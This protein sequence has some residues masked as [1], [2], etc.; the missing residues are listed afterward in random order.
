MHYDDIYDEYYKEDIEKQNLAE[1]NRKKLEALPIDEMVKII[2]SDYLNK[3][4]D[5]DINELA[6]RLE[7]ETKAY[8]ENNKGE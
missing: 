3:M 5:C 8:K 1:Q 2:F 7:K 4:K 6:N